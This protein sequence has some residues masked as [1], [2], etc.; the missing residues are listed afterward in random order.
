MRGSLR[1]LAGHV[2]APVASTAKP[3]TEPLESGLVNVAPYVIAGIAGAA[4]VFYTVP[5]LYGSKVP[6][7][8]SADWKAMELRRSLAQASGKG[9]AAG[10]RR[11]GAEALR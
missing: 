7:T 10:R 9:W 6:H 1:R 8:M 11:G 3:W 5:T 4:A 2:S